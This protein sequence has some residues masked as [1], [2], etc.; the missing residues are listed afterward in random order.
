MLEIILSEKGNILLISNQLIPAMDRSESTEKL[1]RIN[2][3][4]GAARKQVNHFCLLVV[5]Q[6]LRLQHLKSESIYT[7]TQRTMPQV[8][9]QI[10]KPRKY[11]GNFSIISIILKVKCKTNILICVAADGREKHTL[12]GRDQLELMSNSHKILRRPGPRGADQVPLY[13]VP[14][15]TLNN[16]QG[17]QLR[18]MKEA[19]YMF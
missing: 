1:P 3:K 17:I 4:T 5:S 14:T 18:H 13:L 10:D 8:G 19:H 11:H 15:Q 16:H 6:T 7:L 9:P 2:H 12:G